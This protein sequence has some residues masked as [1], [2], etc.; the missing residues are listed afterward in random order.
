MVI[1]NC[2]WTL[3]LTTCLELIFV[4]VF[5]VK[6]LT[7]QILGVFFF[8]VIGQVCR[9]REISVM[10]ECPGCVRDPLAPAQV[11]LSRAQCR[12]VRDRAL[13]R[14]HLLIVRAQHRH[15]NPYV[16]STLSR[17]GNPMSWNSLS[18]HRN[19]KHDQTCHNKEKPCRDIFYG[20]KLETMLRHKENHVAT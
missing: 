12:V 5:L 7:P 9:N 17:H 6:T 13:Y 8:L 11:L 20:L 14:A 10:T 19:P 18:R 3:Y 15:A 1:L 2:W 16:R 4:I